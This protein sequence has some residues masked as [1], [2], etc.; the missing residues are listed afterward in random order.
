MNV[1][2]L[3]FSR[4]L[5][6]KIFAPVKTL[7]DIKMYYYLLLNKLYLLKC[8][9]IEAK[10]DKFA[11]IWMKHTIVIESYYSMNCL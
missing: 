10:F 9:L 11:R 1:K 2:V 5:F 4:D 8:N 7:P 6:E 3:L